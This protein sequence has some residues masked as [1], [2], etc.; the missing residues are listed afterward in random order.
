MGMDVAKLTAIDT[1]VHVELDSCGRLS[2]PD[3]FV[4]A[5]TALFAADRH[6]LSID[7]IAERASMRSVGSR[8]RVQFSH[9]S[10]RALI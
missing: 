6:K 3:D 4:E 5:S 10:P 7:E 8:R 2:L 9:W 1:H